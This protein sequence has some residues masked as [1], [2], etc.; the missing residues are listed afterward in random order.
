M[1]RCFLTRNSC[2][3]EEDGAFHGMSLIRCGSLKMGSSA[4]GEC[5]GCRFDYL[6]SRLKHRV[7]VVVKSVL[8][9]T[10]EGF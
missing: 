10:K 4:F 9:T 2:R 1:P 8:V 5:W 3:I 6:A 7:E